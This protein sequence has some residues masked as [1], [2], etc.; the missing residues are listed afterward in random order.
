[1][2]NNYRLYVWLL[3]LGAMAAGFG[4]LFQGCAKKPTEAPNTTVITGS[5][6]ITIDQNGGLDYYSFTGSGRNYG[7]IGLYTP[8][9]INV[10]FQANGIM[11]GSGTTAPETGY[12]TS[13]TVTLGQTYFIR[14][15]TSPHYGR[16]V[17]TG[18]SSNSS[19]HTITVTF[20][21]VVQTEAG[22]RS[23]Q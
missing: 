22:N 21:W 14:T 11:T 17:V 9:G 5:G 10:S 19:A 1:M 7:K 3:L 23:L 8:D 4:L 16:L 15:D 13:S 18:S 12:G 2:K 20:D 6:A